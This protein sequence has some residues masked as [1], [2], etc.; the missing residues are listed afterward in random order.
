MVRQGDVLL[1]PINRVADEH[2]AGTDTEGEGRR[3]VLAHGEVTGH[4]HAIYP[5]RDVAESV[6]EP[7]KPPRLYNLTNP[8]MFSTLPAKLLRLDTRAL[9]RHE[10][11]D[12]ISLPAGDY[13]AI[14][15]HEGDEIEGLR[16][17]Q[18]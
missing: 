3:I 13:L 16:R 11:H 8:T 1:V 15:Q 2:L 10:E 12:A 9:V 17:V 18:D 6:A 14:I 4:A 7:A 5:D